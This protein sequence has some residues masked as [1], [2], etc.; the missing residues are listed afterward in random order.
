MKPVGA[1]PPVIQKASAV[2]HRNLLAQQVFPC[3]GECFPQFGQHLHAGICSSSLQPLDIAP[4]NARQFRQSFLSDSQSV[5][6]AAD[7]ASKDN[8]QIRFQ[9]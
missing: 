3:A 5:T 1:L 4:V 7:I 8:F 9:S 6:N 2:I